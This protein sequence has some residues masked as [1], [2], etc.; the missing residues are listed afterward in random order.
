MIYVA[1]ILVVAGWLTF[2]WARLQ[3]GNANM[4]ALVAG[5][6]R[7]EAQAEYDRCR[8]EL[9]VW[10]AARSSMPAVAASHGALGAEAH[11]A[12]ERK[13]I[14]ALSERGAWMMDRIRG[15]D[16]EQTGPACRIRAKMDLIDA[17]A[18]DALGAG[19]RD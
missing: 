13:Q 17:A 4:A 7:A 1:V 15:L 16:G 8:A 9:S 14:D 2:R 18:R 19:T 5:M 12:P 11:L 3:S 6:T 10:L